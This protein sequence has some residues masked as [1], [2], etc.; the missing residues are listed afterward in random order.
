MDYNDF[1]G[2]SDEEFF[3]MIASF[4]NENDEEKDDN[5]YEINPSEWTKE[6]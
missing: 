6:I 3:S 4:L 5:D 1:S 2:M